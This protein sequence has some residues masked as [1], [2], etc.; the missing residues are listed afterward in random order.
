VSPRSA[1]ADLR[2]SLLA[3]AAHIVANEGAAALSL[4]R[5]AAEVGTSTMAIY[6]HFGSMVQLRRAVRLHAFARFGQAL[7]AVERTDDP[8]ADLIL[9]GWAYYGNGLRDPDLYRAMFMETPLDEEDAGVGVETFDVL[10]EAVE[11][12]IAAGRFTADDAT[13]VALQLW[14]LQHGAVSLQLTGF[15]DADQAAATTTTVGGHLLEAFGDDP[16]TLAA[17]FETATRRAATAGEPSR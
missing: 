3:A 7:A 5:L 15:L 14:V 1:D 4:R 2:R 12:C 6:T 13:A 9:L 11:R 16:L 17:S 10:V 8:V